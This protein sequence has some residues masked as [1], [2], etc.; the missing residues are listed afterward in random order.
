MNITVTY[1]KSKDFD[2]YKKQAIFNLGYAYLSTE[3]QA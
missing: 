3:D 2:F 1:L